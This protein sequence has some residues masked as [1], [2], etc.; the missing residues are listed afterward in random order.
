MPRYEEP[1]VARLY[2]MHSSHVR[3][4]LPDTGVDMDRCPL[5]FRTY[6][7][8]R[9]V[10]LPGR[11]FSLDVSLG[12]ALRQRTSIRAFALQPLALE[13]LGRLLYASYGVRGY[14][15][16]EGQWAVDRP[17]PSAGGRYP[18]EL[19]VV[20]QAITGLPDGLY[21]YDARAHQLEQRRLGLLQPDLAGITMG[22]DMIRDANLVVVI[23]AIFARTTWKYGQRGYRYVWLD[24]GHVGQNLY[25]VATALGLGPAA[26]GGFFDDE[27]NRL[28]GL[29]CDEEEAVYV[30]CIGQPRA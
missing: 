29:P 13:A 23:T 9:R 15:Q 5:L 6:V 17:A 21:H 10:D 22:Q 16:I 2:H 19:Y 26:I 1:D 18:L 12:A 11:D 7:G 4:R 24:A 28:L 3:A 20:S 14:R 8:S 25:L 27:L 30:M